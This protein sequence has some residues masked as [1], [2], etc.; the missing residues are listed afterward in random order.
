MIGRFSKAY[1]N[2]TLLC[3]LSQ[4][5]RMGLEIGWNKDGFEFV[6]TGVDTGLHSTCTDQ[7]Q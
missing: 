3:K 6:S 2:R 5:P 4:A 1:M 7:M